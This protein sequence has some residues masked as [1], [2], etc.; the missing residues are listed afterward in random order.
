MRDQAER[1]GDY[2]REVLIGPE[3]SVL[4]MAKRLDPNKAT[5]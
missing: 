3:T 1:V 5:S 4:Q 2:E